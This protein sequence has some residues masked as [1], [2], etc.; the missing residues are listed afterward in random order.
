M[1][2][3][4][5]T[6]W[7]RISFPEN[8]ILGNRVAKKL[9]LENEELSAGDK[10]LIREGVKNIYWAYTLKPSTCPV[11][12]Y[13][14]NER[15]YLEIAVL[16]IELNKPK[17]YKRIAEII[18]RL[19]PYPLLIGFADERN[20]ALSIAPKRYSQAE[21]GV[22]VAEHFYTTEWINCTAP[23]EYEK[24]FL[25]SLNWSKQKLHN[26]YTLYGS[27]QDCF[28]GYECGKLS[29]EFK[30]GDRNSRSEMLNK[31]RE[32]EQKIAEMR[33]QIKGLD[34]NKQ[35]ELNTEIKKMQVEL[36]KLAQNI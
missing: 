18:H 6:V 26:V 17:G 15:E 2:E 14:D 7:D 36:K 32:I 35:V 4:L 22:Y 16:E 11:I 8:A 9:F 34:F 25:E 21:K 12:P 19:I 23:V 24:D 33:S 1:L 13:R 29:G 5:K 27:W 28:I 10:K 30:L 3:A 20:I 31:T